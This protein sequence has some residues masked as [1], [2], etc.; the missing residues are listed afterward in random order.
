MTGDASSYNGT[1]VV[2]RSTQLN[3]PIIFVSIN[4]R[5]N[6][7]G[8]LGGSEVTAAGLGNLGLQ[9]RLYYFV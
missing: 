8:F 1:Q 9:D 2:A 3:Q 7:F 4:Y 6:A 5:V